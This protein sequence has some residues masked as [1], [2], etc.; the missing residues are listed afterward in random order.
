MASPSSHNYIVLY[1]PEIS[2]QSNIFNWIKW[3]VFSRCNSK[4]SVCMSFTLAYSVSL[5]FKKIRCWFEGKI[6]DFSLRLTLFLT[7]ITYCLITYNDAWYAFYLWDLLLSCI[8]SISSEKLT[9]SVENKDEIN[10]AI[11]HWDNEKS[12]KEIGRKKTMV[13]ETLRCL[14]IWKHQV[15]TTDNLFIF[16]ILNSSG[17]SF[18]VFPICYFL[19]NAY[20]RWIHMNLSY[21][22]VLVTTMSDNHFRT[23]A[24]FC[25][26]LHK[27]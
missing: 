21:I 22:N 11:V 13:Q 10:W 3:F 27:L 19:T 7:F 2:V 16:N 15:A 8:L 12:R 17:D 5:Y 6:S 24:L 26:V 9:D 20:M 18:S 14:L 4:N 1:K 23:L 25:R